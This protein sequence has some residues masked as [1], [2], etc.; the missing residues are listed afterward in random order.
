MVHSVLI[1][2]DNAFIRH[3]L[4][5][6]FDGQLDFQVCGEAEN[7]REAIQIAEE[8]LPEA[9]IIDLSMPVMNGLDAARIIKNTLPETKI[10]LFSNH[11]GIFSE[12]EALSAGLSAVVS[13]A[14]NV[15]ELVGK[16]REV[17]YRAVLH[18]CNI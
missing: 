15:S 6:V 11:G 18:S 13:K 5:Q 2:D 17:I 1:V 10:I 12:R 16:A 7:G 14:Q 4:R 3:Q 8:L 9:V